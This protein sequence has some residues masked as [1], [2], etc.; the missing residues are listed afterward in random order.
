MKKILLITFFLTIFLYAQNDKKITLQLNWLNQFQFAGYYM[1]K[2]KGFYKDL[3][4]DVD[5]IEFNPKTNIVD[6]V[7]NGNADYGLTYSSLFADYM[8]GKPLV[9]VSNFFKQSPLVIVTQKNIHTPADLKGKKVM[10]LLD[11]SHKD[12]I[13]GMLDRFDVKPT[14][15]QNITREFTLDSFINLF[16]G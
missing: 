8:Q 12:L 15:L 11:S 6:E 4:L 2:E 9:F 13:L 14:D 5:F 10:G 1:A 7:L 16:P 3:G